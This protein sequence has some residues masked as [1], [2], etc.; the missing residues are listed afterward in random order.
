MKTILEAIKEKAA[1]CAERGIMFSLPSVADPYVVEH[2]DY[3]GEGDFWR[4][5]DGESWITI[6]S[7]SRDGSRV[8]Q[9]NPDRSSI[10]VEGEIPERV[11]FSDSWNESV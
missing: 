3:E 11:S 5:E 10:V 2:Q 1:R 8:F 7:K 6:E 4:L 9:I